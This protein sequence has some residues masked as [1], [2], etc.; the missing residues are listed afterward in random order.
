VFE[1]VSDSWEIVIVAIQT[2][3]KQVSFVN[4]FATTQGGRH[5]T[6]VTEIVTSRILKHFKSRI[7]KK[8]GEQELLASRHLHGQAS[9]VCVRK[10]FG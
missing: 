7:R 3:F 6:Y 8:E 5:V 2:G 1:S 10:L 4:K 9:L